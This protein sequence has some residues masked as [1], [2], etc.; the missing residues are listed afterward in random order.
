MKIL[1]SMITR[2]RPEQGSATLVLLALLAIMVMLTL[3]DNTALLR[4]RSE[5]RLI[6]HRQVQRL[7]N[8]MTNAPPVARVIGMAEGK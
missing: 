2:P 1:R 5:L 7:N 6:E 4:L 8:S 3:A